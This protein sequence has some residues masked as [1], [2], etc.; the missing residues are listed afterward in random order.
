MK[1]RPPSSTETKSQRRKQKDI[2]R[3]LSHSRVSFLVFVL[4]N[5]SAICYAVETPTRLFFSDAKLSFVVP[6]PWEV[7]S[8]F[9][10]GP[11]LT[12]KT[13]E[14]T[15]AFVVCQISDPVDLTR[16]SADASTDTLKSFATRDLS[17]RQTGARV[18]ATAPRKMA[19]QNAYEV[20]WLN[21]GPE[22]VTQYQ[23][24]Y[25]FLDN[26]FYVLSL[27][28]NRDSFPWIVQDFQNWLTSVHLLNRQD[29]GKL[30]A[31]AHGGMWVHQT[32]GAKITFPEGWLIGVAD[33]RQVGATIAHDKM[34][35]DFSAVVDALTPKT[36]EMPMAEKAEAR[37]AL[38][39]KDYK[40]LT[41]TDEPFHGLPAHQIVYEGAAEGGRFIHGQDLWV[42][43]PK[44]RWLINMEGDSRLWRQLSDEWQAILSNIHFYE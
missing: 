16:L 15:D 35:L 36:Q 11:L 28:A 42:W 8:S 22:G 41:E 1:N 17:S 20:T 12:R 32:G 29:S 37:K 6:E 38:E 19:G 43:S 40:V 14:G 44:A 27:K 9:P 2:Q 7:P 25:F 3:R 26:R 34:H 23:S 10:F 33:D 13:Q 30:R 24:I 5:L 18:L 4:L 31:P 39:A 21:E